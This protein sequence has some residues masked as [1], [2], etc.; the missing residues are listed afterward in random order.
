[1][2]RLGGSLS[3][4]GAD[5]GR[6]GPKM[7][8]IWAIRPGPARKRKER[9]SWGPFGAFGGPLGPS[10]AP[11]GPSW[12]VLGDSGCLGALLEAS[13]DPLGSLFGP[14]WGS[15]GPSWGPLGPSWGPLGLLLGRLGGLL[16]RF[17]ALSGTFG[18]VLGRSLEPLE[19]FWAV[20]GPKR[21][22]PEKLSKTIEKSMIFASW[23]PLGKP[24]GVLLGRL[25]APLDRLE[26]SE[27]PTTRS[28]RTLQMPL[29]HNPGTVA[30]WAE[31]H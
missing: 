6:L 13:W 25:G 3:D 10:W 4:F 8:E 1:M 9:S 24:F 16:G 22:E 7:A 27:R 5:L 11:F 2:G 28:Q 21:R 30:G 20:L 19:P 18:A 14:S 26:A 15:H 12:G 31:G 29:T 23:S 17:R